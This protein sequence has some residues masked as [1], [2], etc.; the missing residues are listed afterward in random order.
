[1]PPIR[2]I[3]VDDEP[4]A[5]ERLRTWFAREADFSVVG[6]CSQ[7][8]E[9]VEVLRRER[10]DLV[11]LDVQMPGLTGVQVLEALGQDAPP[12]VVFVTA[13]EHFAVDAFEVQAVD[14]LLKPVSRERFKTALERVA[15]RLAGPGPG[16]TAGPAPADPKLP[17][18]LSVKHNG[19]II[20]VPVAD[21][22]W[23]GSADNYVELHVGAQT[24]LLRE[25]MTAIT[26]RLPADRFVRISRTAIVQVG[27][28]RHLEPLFHGEYSVE[29]MSGAKLTL[30][31]SHR[32]QLPRLGVRT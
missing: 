21:I 32:D 20:F 14:Y 16:A 28:V 5:R 1:M 25:T 11:F 17:E 15:K 3:V 7:G 9:A 8:E 13:H 12:A 10:P 30:S 6:E 23:V 29:L 27:R 22:D 24:F 2:T 26:Q 31:R 19:R 18:R 4:L